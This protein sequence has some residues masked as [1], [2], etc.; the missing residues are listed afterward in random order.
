MIQFIYHKVCSFK[1]R[2]SV[3]FFVFVF[4]MCTELYNHHDNLFLKL[5]W[6]LSWAALPLG[7]M[8]P[9]CSFSFFKSF[10]WSI[11]ALQRLC[12]FLYSQVNQSYIYTYPLFFRFPLHLGHH[13]ALS[14][15]PF[16]IYQVLHHSNLILEQKLA[17]I[18][19]K[20]F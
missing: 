20:V 5:T 15:V 17:F 11:V 7:R 14:R 12:Q 19:Y 1:V 16:A 4:C 18:L 3:V 9:S 13:R 6:L 8:Q 2:N 10:Y